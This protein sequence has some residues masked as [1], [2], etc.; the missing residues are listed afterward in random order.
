MIT[1]QPEAA[2]RRGARPRQGRVRAVIRN[3]TFTA[4]LGLAAVAG[5]A[6]SPPAAGKVSGQETGAHLGSACQGCRDDTL[7]EN[8]IAAHTALGAEERSCT[9]CH[10]GA[11]TASHPVGFVPGRALPDAFPLGAGGAM[12]CG[13]CHDLRRGTPGLLRATAD[14]EHICRSCHETA[15][16]ADL[17]DPVRAFMFSGHLDT[18]GH[19][20]AGIDA[21][22]LRCMVCHADQGPTSRRTASISNALLYD[23]GQSNHSIGMDYDAAAH[24]GGYEPITTL[25]DE[26]FLPEGRVACVSCHV[27]Y[28]RKHGRRPQ[29]RSGL[30]LS[31]H[32]L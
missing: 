14:G 29:T 1:G 13:T 23:A 2:A 10:A 32:A 18:G 25:P 7:P 26:V 11:A 31:C 20:A 30:C 21:F 8:R 4:A 12:T 3:L 22:S 17:P 27:P 24:T 5:M 28:S 19:S 9:S 6:G 16:F 15:L